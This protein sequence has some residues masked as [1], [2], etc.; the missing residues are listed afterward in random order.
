MRQTQPAHQHVDV[1]GQRR[2]LRDVSSRRPPFGQA[3]QAR[4]HGAKQGDDAVKLGVQQS[5]LDQGERRPPVLDTC[6]RD[7]VHQ[8][9]VTVER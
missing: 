5:V 6:D 7:Q 3:S 9:A 4:G 2:R 1:V 8:V